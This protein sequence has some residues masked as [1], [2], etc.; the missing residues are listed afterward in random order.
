MY[1][2]KNIK[3]ENEIYIYNFHSL[4]FQ[5]YYVVLNK[6][7]CNNKGHKLYD[8]NIEIQNYL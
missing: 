3:R 5:Y 4:L 8:T 2:M 7:A 1:I 6:N